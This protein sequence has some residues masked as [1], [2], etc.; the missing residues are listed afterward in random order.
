MADNRR[1]VFVV[2]DD[3][4]SLAVAKVALKERYNALTVTPARNC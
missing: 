4:T 2:D 1:T 3:L